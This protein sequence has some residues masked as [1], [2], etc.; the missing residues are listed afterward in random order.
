MAPGCVGRRFLLF[1]ITSFFLKGS[2]TKDK[3][4]GHHNARYVSFSSLLV[5]D[6]IQS[7]ATC[8]MSKSVEGVYRDG[9][10]ELTELP[11]SVP[12]GTRVVVT[13]PGTVYDL[14]ERGI[15]ETLGADLRTD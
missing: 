3:V 11:S 8:V 9:K 13:F 2:V 15:D 7:I 10:I 1:S 4:V 14:R 5:L 12:E 6:S